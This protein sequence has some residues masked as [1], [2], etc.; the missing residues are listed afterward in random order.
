MIELLV[1]LALLALGLGV[2]RTVE[3]SHYRS[4]REREARSMGTPAVSF[5]T[6]PDDRPVRDAVLVQGGVVISVDYFKRFLAGIRSIFGGEVRAYSSLIDRARREAVL[7]MR[8]SAPH[9]DLFLNCRI[10]TA[11][12]ARASGKRTVAGV[13]VFAYAT[14]IYFEHAVRA[15]TAG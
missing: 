10:E 1:F 8:E 6:L 13:E 5:R 3:R 4:I 7:R 14:A 15:E 11:S 9:A 2:G 12:I